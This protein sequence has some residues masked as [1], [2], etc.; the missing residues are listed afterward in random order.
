L[1]DPRALAGLAVDDIE[2]L[3]DGGH[4]FLSRVGEYLPDGD[5]IQ[6]VGRGRSSSRLRV[7]EVLLKA[8]SR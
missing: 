1:L 2:H 8:L 5:E 7:F 3:V 6:S 4:R